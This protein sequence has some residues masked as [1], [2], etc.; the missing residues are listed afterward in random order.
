MTQESGRTITPA[1]LL[2][3]LVMFAVLALKRQHLTAE[4]AEVATVQ[5]VVEAQNT[6]V[7]DWRAAVAVLVLIAMFAFVIWTVLRAKAGEDPAKP[8]AEESSA[9]GTREFR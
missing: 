2:L 4:E 5:T 3:L 8:P 9:S 7:K 6:L 1:A